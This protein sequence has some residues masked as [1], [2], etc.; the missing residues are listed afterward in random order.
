MSRKSPLPALAVIGASALIGAGALGPVESSRAATQDRAPPA[1][2]DALPTFPGV[3]ELPFGEG[4]SLNGAPMHLSSGTTAESPERVRDF[5]LEWFERRSEPAEVSPIA[6]GGYAI[7]AQI[8]SGAA[9]A[10]VVILSREGRTHVFPCVLELRLVT[11]PIDPALPLTA[12][13]RGIVQLVGR[14]ETSVSYEEP[15]ESVESLLA[16][17]DRAMQEQ[18]FRPERRRS[19]SL[20]GE[21]TL[22]RGAQRWRFDV[23]AGAKLEG[24]SVLARYR[25]QEALP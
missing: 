3:V 1:V 23:A 21:L 5:Y 22:A 24:V 12:K 20:G 11:P 19:D 15:A 13:A 14:E 25:A 8:Q 6:G 7:S 16:H 2:A 9:R 4:Y 18:G 10:S 17:L